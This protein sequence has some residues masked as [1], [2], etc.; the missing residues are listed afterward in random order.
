MMRFGRGLFNSRFHE[1]LVV[2]RLWLLVAVIFAAEWAVMIA[3]RQSAQAV[4]IDVLLLVALVV[5]V[6][7]W[8]FCRPI[9]RIIA[10]KDRAIAGLRESEEKYRSLVKS[11]N[12]AIITTDLTTGLLQDVND[13]AEELFGM[14]REKLIG[15][16]FLDTHPAAERERMAKALPEIVKAG[17]I[18]IS[19]DFNL[20][21]ADGTPIPL[22]AS[23]TVSK[24]GD[25]LL[26]IGIFHDL[27]PRRE[28]E[29]QL[30]LLSAALEA[31]A[32]GI[33]ITDRDGIIQWINPAFT[34][35]TGYSFEEAR[36]R[37]TRMFKSGRHDAAFYRDMWDTILAGR[38][39]RGELVNRRKDGGLCD[40]MMVITPVRTEDGEITHFVAIKEDIT[41]R[42]RAQEEA[43]RAARRLEETQEMAHVGSWEWDI[44]N[45]RV[46]RSDMVYEIFRTSREEFEPTFEGYLE[47][48]HPED[49]DSVRQATEKAIAA[50]GSYARDHRLLLRDGSV[51]W[52][53]DQGVMQLDDGGNPMRLAGSVQDITERKRTE[54]L[55]RKSETLLSEA[56]RIAHVGSWEWDIE[57]DCEIWSDE[58]YRIFG[59]EPREVPATYDLFLAALHP[60]DRDRVMNAVVDVL[61]GGRPYDIEFRIV[62]ENGETRHIH[63]RAEVTRNLEGKPIRMAGTVLD[64]TRQKL[65]ELELRKLT[66]A[67]EHSPSIAMITDPDARI[68]YVNPRFTEVTG[69]TA[70]EAIG[71]N[72]T[73]MGA[74]SDAEHN[75]MWE[76]LNEKGV[77]RGQFLNHRKNGESYWEQAAISALKV[78]DGQISHYV[79]VAQDITAQKRAEEKLLAVNK[80]LRDFAHTVSHDL[81]GQMRGIIGYSR[82]LS[83]RHAGDLGERGRFCAKQVDGAT[84]KLDAMLEDLLEFSR[85]GGESAEP[86][87]ANLQ[88]MVDSVLDVHKA[89]I[90]ALGV[91]LEVRLE[92]PV[93]C[94]WATGTLQ[95]LQNLIGN[96]LKYSRSARPPRICITGGRVGGAYRLSVGDNGIGFDMKHHDRLFGLFNRL[97]RAEDYEGTGAGLAIAEKI[98]DRQGGRIWAESAPGCGA[99]FHMELPRHAHEGLT[100][101]FPREDRQ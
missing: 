69:Y 24:F 99:T 88:V 6:A 95:V 21:H 33:A 37:N 42:K 90:E 101:H 18:V 41:E 72:A 47:Y 3:L 48:V 50:L 35:L 26:G 27:R 8:A 97:V 1:R 83:T 40:E 44:R 29:R 45:N 91:E 2:A 87:E 64:I 4:L 36:G 60:D 100:P 16:H 98:V 66:T 52:V 49:R 25:R 12:D 76:E 67:V 53:H 34:Q 7:Y 77:W 79:K 14:P 20:L 86:A 75:R 84:L 10:V 93:L 74:Q 11:A 63:A 73:T 23:V 9:L 62:R 85:L 31:A 57:T 89:D 82:E 68:E 78:G 61:E 56:Q 30:R 81:K 19:E 70:E 5:P 38:S 94:C 15:M 39:W 80:E 65:V 17:R 46:W 96:A 71:M 54:E 92:N 55:L 28:A 58:Q 32:N 13:K 51:V 59:Y 43:Q 22:E